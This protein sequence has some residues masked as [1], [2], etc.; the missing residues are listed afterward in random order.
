MK[1]TF[2]AVAICA[3]FVVSCCPP[4]CA[5][6]PRCDFED[7]LGFDPMQTRA[8]LANGRWRVVSGNM[9]MLDFGDR[10]D[11]AEQSVEIIQFYKLDEQCFVG[12]PDPSLEYWKVKGQAPSGAMPG[13]DC[14]SFNPDNIVVQNVAGS[15]KIVEDNNW[16][17]DF[18][19]QEFEAR[20]SL[21]IIKCNGFTNICFVDRP[22]PPMTYFRK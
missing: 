18:G 11:Q 21:K 14:I 5:K 4:W 15:W 13:E 20:T 17:L 12:R 2:L 22:D 19:D 6:P 9:I 16:I 1:T 10:Q 8:E 7:C 3:V